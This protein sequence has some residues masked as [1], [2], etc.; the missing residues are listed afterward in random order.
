MGEQIK[1]IIVEDQRLGIDLLRSCMDDRFAI[2]AAVQT[3]AAGWAAFEE[4][5]PDLAIL[6]IELP[7][8]SGLDL[9]QR[10][11]DNKR[12]IKLLGVSAKTDP[13]T[14]YRVFMMGFSGFVDKNSGSVDELRTAIDQVAQGNFHYASI[15]QDVMREQYANPDAFSKILTER[16]QELLVHLGVGSSN[17]AIAV[18]LGLRPVSVQGHRHRI[19]RKLGLNTTIDLI[20]YAMRTG[21][22]NAF[23]L[24][25]HFTEKDKGP[26][27]RRKA[28]P[29]PGI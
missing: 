20:R 26:A 4:H 29:E 27:K 19:M 23:D 14:L 16:E 21:F 12:H 18:R 22:V 25:A 6:D 3:I 13:Y 17:E 24:K 9:A 11:L 5:D 28:P 15:V 2:C 1:T 7:D 10:L 8:G